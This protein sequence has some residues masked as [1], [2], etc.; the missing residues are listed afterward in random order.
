MKLSGQGLLLAAVTAV[1][2]AAVVVGFL[3]LGTPGEARKSELDRKR[4]EDLRNLSGM[5][6]PADDKPLAPSLELAIGQRG[7]QWQKDPATGK[8][9]G[10]RVVDADHFDLCATFDTEVKEGDLGSW[11]KGWAHPAGPCCFRFDRRYPSLPRK[12]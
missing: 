8:P 2:I 3:A 9:Y 4:I 12:P 5:V 6:T 11:E 10:Y 1:V 7:D